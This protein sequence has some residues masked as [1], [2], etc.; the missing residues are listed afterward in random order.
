MI[1]AAGDAAVDA[2]LRAMD[3]VRRIEKLPKEQLIAEYRR[4]DLFVLPSL[5][6]SFGLVYAEA[7][8]QGVPVLYSAGQGFDKQFPEGYVG[9]CMDAREPEAVAGAIRRA[10]EHYEQLQ[11]NCAQAAGCFSQEVVC[12]AGEALYE[13]AMANKEMRPQAVGKDRS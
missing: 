13:E 1:G 10:L 12:A 2:Q 3:F 4:A 9:Y 11:K 5:A 7:L 8:S 6:E